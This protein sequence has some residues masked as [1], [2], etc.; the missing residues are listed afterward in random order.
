MRAKIAENFDKIPAFDNGELLFLNGF[1]PKFFVD[2]LVLLC[3][4]SLIFVSSRSRYG[5][6]RVVCTDIR[7]PPKIVLQSGES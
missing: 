1:K 4:S 2:C 6:E 5:R 7:K 3:A